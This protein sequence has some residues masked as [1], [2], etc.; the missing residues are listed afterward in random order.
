MADLARPLA[1]T[2]PVERWA[3]SSSHRLSHYRRASS[4]VLRSIDRSFGSLSF[5][6]SCWHARLTAA[7]LKGVTVGCC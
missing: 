3:V 1:V 7:T 6:F 2:G 4:A 5:V